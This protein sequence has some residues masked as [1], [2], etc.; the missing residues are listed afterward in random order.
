ML[1]TKG[2][3]ERKCSQGG[4]KDAHEAQKLTMMQSWERQR[5][6]FSTEAVESEQGAC[7]T[8]IPA[9]FDLASERMVFLDPLSHSAGECGRVPI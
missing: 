4:Y 5:S 1:Q 8:S 3:E 9:I 2:R 6:P 7:R